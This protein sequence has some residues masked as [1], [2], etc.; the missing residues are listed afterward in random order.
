MS[1]CLSRANLSIQIGLAMVEMFLLLLTTHE[2]LQLFKQWTKEVIVLYIALI[3]Y[4]SIR[5][6]PFQ[7]S[8]FCTHSDASLGIS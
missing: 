7:L 6:S 4:F 5:S 1:C 8:N 2:V 3:G